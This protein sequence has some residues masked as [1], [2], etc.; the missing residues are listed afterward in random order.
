MPRRAPHPR[1]GITAFTLIELLV[2]VAIIAILAALLLPA[3]SEARERGRR[4]VCMNNLRQNTLAFTLYADVNDNQLPETPLISTYPVVHIGIINQAV[5]G[6][7][8]EFGMTQSTMSCPSKPLFEPYDAVGSY[9]AGIENSYGCT[10]GLNPHGTVSLPAALPSS[11]MRLTD[12]PE[13]VMMAD[14]V[15]NR[16]SSLADS[17]SGLPSPNYY[18]HGGDRMAGNNQSFLDGHVTWM[19]RAQYPVAFVNG[20]TAPG[21][22]TVTHHP[23]VD[24]SWWWVVD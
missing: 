16:T 14:L 1:G 17:A 9:P 18:N 7:Y 20:V 2:V 13:D 4:T 24:H 8:Q 11:P 3:L 5:W 12:E 10:F 19:H 22:A 21:N 6:T 15:Y 23:T